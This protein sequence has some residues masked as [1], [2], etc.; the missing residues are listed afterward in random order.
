[1]TQLDFK[2][3]R[4]GYYRVAWTIEDELAKNVETEA[5]RYAEARAAGDFSIAGVIAG[6]ASGLIHDLPS[7]AEI[8]ARV[9]GEAENLLKNGARR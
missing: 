9:A 6:E 8:V 7:A 1:M 5:A 4:E 2:P 3:E